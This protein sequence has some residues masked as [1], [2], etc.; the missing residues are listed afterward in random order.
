MMDT[1]QRKETTNKKTHKA[2]K[3]TK[4]KTKTK[5]KK[6][7]NKKQKIPTKKIVQVIKCFLF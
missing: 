2:K 1:R 6:Q 4:T 5:T 3:K 7:K